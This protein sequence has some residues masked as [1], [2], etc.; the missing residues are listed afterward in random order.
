MSLAALRPFRIGSALDLSNAYLQ[1]RLAPH[2]WRAVG[3][4]VAGR[5]FEY[6]RLPFGYNNSSHEF[7]RA[8]W[9]TVR[10][11]SRR[12]QSQV[13]FYMDDILLLSQSE[14][15]HRQDMVILLE[16]LARDGWRVNW[17]KCQFCRD[18]FEY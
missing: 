11:V 9:P 17:T 15:Q 3:L 5:F 18:R 7:L 1:V 4:A 10:R 6:T 12:I 13:L 8:L 16:E 2:L 14:A